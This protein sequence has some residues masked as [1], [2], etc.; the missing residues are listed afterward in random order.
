M[1]TNSQEFTQ[2]IWTFKD[3]LRGFAISFTR[4]EDDA[5]DLVQETMLK[6]IRYIEKFQ[7][8]TNLK[9]W[10]F[11][12]LKNTFINNYR[13]RNKLK[14]YIAETAGIAMVDVKVNLTLNEGEGKCMMEDIH[15]ELTKLSF[16]CYYP[17]IK[18][19]EGYKYKEIADELQIPIGT[20]KTRIHMARNILKKNLKTYYR[21]FLKVR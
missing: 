6:A 16:D 13:K 20:V 21:D 15:K 18:Y 10:L 4:N 11:M 14:S 9:S 7:Q 19:F 5:D 12:I 2:Q 8:G 3:S 1:E 17:F